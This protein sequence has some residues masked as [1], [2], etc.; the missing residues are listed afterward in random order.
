LPAETN[1]ASVG[2]HK[3]AKHFS[4]SHLLLTEDFSEGLHGH[5]YYVEIEVFGR[6]NKD[7]MIINFLS[8]DKYLT[9]ILT[10][11][12]HYTLLPSKNKDL[13]I[14][15]IG[16]NFEIQFGSRFYSIPQNEIK[17][18][19][20]P[21]VTAEFLAKTIAIHVKGYFQPLDDEH[22]IE[23]VKVSLWET[24]LYYASYSIQLI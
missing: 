6:L 20:C 3:L 5:N 16:N 19:D 14:E 9:D 22:N 4:A 17:L 8:L 11:W 23:E 13:K 12:D 1:K 2:L 18:L 21:N 24:P 15:E 10:Q 7:E